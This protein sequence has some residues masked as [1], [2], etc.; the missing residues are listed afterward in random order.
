M[1][2]ALL[3]GATVAAAVSA[4]AAF[5]LQIVHWN[6]VHARYAVAARSGCKCMNTDGS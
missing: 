3:Y 4:A 6:D 5:D 1:M 2:E